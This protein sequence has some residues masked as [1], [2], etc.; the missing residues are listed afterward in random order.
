MT[1]PPQR[2]LIE[3][4]TR[5]GLVGDTHGDLQFLR[6]AL[7]EFREQGV[8]VVIQLGD[9]GFLWQNGSHDRAALAALDAQLVQNGQTLHWLDGNHEYFTMLYSIPASDDGLRW[10]TPNIAHLPRGHRTTL[11]SG[12][13]LAIL[14]G[15]NSIDIHHRREGTSVWKEESVTEADLTQLG[16]EHADILLAHDAPMDVPAIDTRLAQTSHYWPTGSLAYAEAGRRMYHRGFMAVKPA[17]FMGGHYHFFIDQ[18]VEYN[19]GNDTFTTRVIVLDRDG[20]PLH[21]STAILD[22]DTL[23]I[24]FG[25]PAK[26]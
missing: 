3:H 25:N 2:H 9:F 18:V 4:A 17:I 12:K 15:G 6:A 21:E 20:A 19:A 14:G 16:T 1:N 11:L 8:E 7:E 10:V 26:G 24:T 22:V 5:I 13:S 23:Q